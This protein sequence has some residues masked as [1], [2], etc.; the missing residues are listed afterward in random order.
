MFER[1][2]QI[3]IFLA[4]AGW[5]DASRVPLAGDASGRIYQRLARDDQSV[6][7]MDSWHEDIAPFLHIAQHLER[8]GFSAPKVYTIDSAQRLLLLEDLGDFSFVSCLHAGAMGDDSVG[9]MALYSAAVDVLVALAVEALPSSFRVMDGDYLAGEIGLFTEWWPPQEGAAS[10]LVAEGESWVAA[11]RDVYASALAIPAGLALRDFHAE[12]LI[13]LA[14][15]KGNRRIGLLDFQDALQAPISYDLVSLLQDVRRDVPENL[16][17]E[18]IERFMTALPDQDHSAFL[19]SYAILGAHRNLRIAGI[20]SRLAGRDGN[21]EY[22]K[23]LPRVWRHIETNL[24]H[25]ALAPVQEWLARH[26]PA[27]QREAG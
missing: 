12:N 11:W 13:W 27:G 23:F 5:S 4:A 19:T 14:A 7:L 8:C 6:V 22:L 21:R 15:R 24:R 18:M 1:E 20:F 26:V 3:D 25:P 17:A 9:E 2:Q 16:Q 10:P